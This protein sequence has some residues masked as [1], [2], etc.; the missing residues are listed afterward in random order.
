MSRRTT[1]AVLFPLSQ[2]PGYIRQTLALNEPE[3][4]AEDG[5]DAAVAVLRPWPPL[6]EIKEQSSR[7]HSGVC[8]DC[9]E[10]YAAYHLSSLWR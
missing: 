6:F 5:D 2:E 1:E 8:L 9:A 10:Q 4:T 7:G 3:A